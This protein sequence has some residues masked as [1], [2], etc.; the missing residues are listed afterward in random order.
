MNTRYTFFSSV[1][2][3]LLK[4]VLYQ[5]TLI[6]GIGVLM[7]VS[8]SIF[9]T[10]Q[11]LSKWGIYIFIIAA[12]LMALG[13]IPYRHLQRLEE[14]PNK[15]TLSE[16][17]LLHYYKGKSL[18]FSIPLKDI[19]SISWMENPYLYGIKLHIKHDK[20]KFLPFFS[21]RSYNELNEA[22]FCD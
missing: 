20:F 4:K 7:L 8:A 15:I 21:K 3:K 22:L 9:S 6:A 12:F 17:G 11:F 18:S 16:N 13:L 14:N 10:P 2:P 5:G 1:H 19:Q